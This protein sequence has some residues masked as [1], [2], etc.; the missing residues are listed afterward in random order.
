MLDCHLEGT[1]GAALFRNFH[2][3]VAQYLENLQDLCSHGTM[4]I[5]PIVH[6]FGRSE[7]EEPE[8][9]NVMAV[10]GGAL[11]F[12][13]GVGGNNPASASILGAMSG[14]TAIIG[15]ASK[16][17]SQIPNDEMTE[18]GLWAMLQG[19]CTGAKER[20]L[21]SL[22]AVTGAPGSSEADIPQEMKVQYAE[23]PKYVHAISYLFGDGQWLVDQPTEG[24]VENFDEVEAQLVSRACSS[25][26][27]RCL[28]N[29][30]HRN[31]AWPGRC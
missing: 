16:D 27:R 2:T 20:I 21:N 22:Q 24:L 30:L 29:R 1:D 23:D 11:S 3:F 19:T 31:K 25:L 5:R 8:S 15:E 14:I 4:M 26:Q 18:D 13:A 7:G 6:K 12:G 9:I 28:T 17:Q 10:L